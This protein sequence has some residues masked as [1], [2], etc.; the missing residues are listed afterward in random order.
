[1]T[2]RNKFEAKVAARLG[3]GFSYE[4]AKLGYVI[5]HTYLPD[6]VRL[7]DAGDI[8]EIVEAKGRF[9]AEDRRKMKAIRVLHPDMPITIAFQSPNRLIAKNSKTTYAGWCEKNGIA[10]T[11]G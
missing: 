1:V 2:Y 8:I 3:D 7:N 9:T 4:A 11:Q 5:S 10:W 6:F